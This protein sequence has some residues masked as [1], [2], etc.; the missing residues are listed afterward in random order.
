MPR[1]VWK[2]VVLAESAETIKLEGRHYFPPGSLRREHLRESDR[3]TTCPWKGVTSYFDVVA[4]D[5]V[6][7][8]AAW[9]YRKPSKAAASIRD[10]VAFWKGVRIE[11]LEDEARPL[12]ARVREAVGL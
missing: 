8:A 9:T 4:E 3:R 2:G 12:L 6:N 5:G 10:H 1:A 7:E 11:P